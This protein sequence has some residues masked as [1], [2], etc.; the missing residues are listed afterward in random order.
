V[1]KGLFAPK[2]GPK[3][4]YFKETNLKKQFRKKEKVKKIWSLFNTTFG[5]VV[6]FGQFFKDM[7]PIN[8]IR[9][10]DLV[11]IFELCYA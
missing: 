1:Y 5:T 4:S 11:S 7:S 2:K 6:Q 3:L 9:I 10:I 8:L